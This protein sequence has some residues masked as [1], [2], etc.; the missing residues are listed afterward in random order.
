MTQIGRK[1]TQQELH[2]FKPYFAHIVLES[3]RII[4]GKVP[5]WLRRDMCAVVLGHRIY[6]RAGYYQP[7]TKLGVELLGHELTHVSQYLHGM[8]ILK[9]CWSCRKGYYKS[10]YE[11]EAYAKGKLIARDYSEVNE[12]YLFL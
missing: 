11:T 7:N 1:L 5:F 6:F 8:T 3:A 2:I 10:M 9:Y 12:Q 4:D